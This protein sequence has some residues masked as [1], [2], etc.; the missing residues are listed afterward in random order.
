MEEFGDA[1]RPLWN[2][3]FGIDAGNFVG[4]WGYPHAQKPPE[5][6]ADFF[7]REQ[8]RQW[9]AC[10]DANRGLGLYAKL[11]PYQFAAGNERDDDHQ[12]RQ[13][14]QLAAGMTIDDYGF[15][16]VRRDG[17]TPRPVCDWLLREQVNRAIRSEPACEADIRFC[18]PKNRVPVGYDYSRQGDELIIRR[19]KIQSAYPTRIQ[20]REGGP[21]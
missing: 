17:R 6:D 20:L 18:P 21:R 9:Q 2:T 15:G 16:I 4:A 19:V 7:D 3:E 11:L 1:G 8:Q 14:A 5:K 13:R 10:L 12:I